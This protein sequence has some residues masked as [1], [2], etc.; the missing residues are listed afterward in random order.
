M[1]LLERARLLRSVGYDDPKS[2][3]LRCIVRTKYWVPPES[4]FRTS[5]NLSFSYS[6]RA[7]AFSHSRDA[8]F[9]GNGRRAPYLSA[10]VQAA[11]GRH[12]SK[13]D[14]SGRYRVLPMGFGFLSCT[15]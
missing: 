8:S 4:R 9:E 3:H 14:T 5:Y 1:T 6:H 10:M 12:C 11:A 15:S 13:L 2:E 7:V